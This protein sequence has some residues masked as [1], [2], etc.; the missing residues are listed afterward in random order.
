MNK[1]SIKTTALL[2][3]IP[4]LL[5]AM[6]IVSLLG[7]TTSRKTLLE[8]SNREM[9]YRLDGVINSIETSLSN[10]RKVV[11]TLAKSVESMKD[12]MT[13][14]DYGKVLTSFIGT[15]D[16]TF[17]GG[18]WFEPYAYDTAVQ[19]FSPYC[20]RENGQ[21][22]Y[23]DNYSLGDGVYYTEQ[24][25]YTGAMN[26][27]ESAVW[28]EP[29]YDDFAKISMVTSSAPFYDADGKL[30]GIA[31][32]DIDLTQLQTM[33]TSMDIRG[34]RAFLISS[35]GTYIADEDDGKLLAQN[36]TGEGTSLA[37]L[38]KQI[39]SQKNGTGSYQENGGNQLVWY[40]E[41]PESGW[42]AVISVSEQIL[43]QETTALARSLLIGCILFALL[44]S[45][46]MYNFIKRKIVLPLRVLADTTQQIA[47]GNLDVSLNSHADNE[48]GTVSRTLEKTVTQ[49]RNYTAYINEISDSLYSIAGGNLVFSLKYD[50]A[51][52][53]ARIKD[54]LNDISS[55]LSTAMA[56][57]HDSSL[58]VSKGSEQIAENG[59]LLASGTAEQSL[60]IETLAVTVDEINEAVHRN[61]TNANKANERVDYVDEEITKSSGKMN[62]MI[63]AM[64]KISEQSNQTSQIIKTIEEI[65]TQT[66]M[67][68]MNAAIEA[69]RAGEAGRGFAVV[70]DQVRELANKSA[71]AVK[72]TNALIE[73]TLKA[74]EQGVNIADDTASSLKHVVDGANEVA[75]LI[76]EISK[77]SNQQASTVTRIKQEI[78]QISSVVKNNSEIAEESAS[79]SEELSA[80]SQLLQELV[81]RF[82]F[83][84]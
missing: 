78:N 71:E 60:S 26:I 52:E 16:E 39:L 42:I 82:E 58:R 8:S 20:M 69:A 48:I 74:V 59:Q 15:N 37:A 51:G 29:Y 11:E 28:S 63:N 54:A 4:T 79:A 83:N 70:A 64:A 55:S 50:Y 17:G 1:K 75:G 19:Y 6:V 10:N 65:A 45:M 56:S 81:S 2:I 5:V 47:D 9:T 27:K 76:E 25:W 23:V 73:L 22:V 49:L 13:G 40:A 61:A 31:T 80:Q 34:G 68:S 7:Y 66:N 21:V 72:D 18:I 84:N 33:I 62:D 41:V 35:A 46:L 30:M 77:D 36:I 53:F 38:G 12:H 67:L 43:M 24:D 32:T 3:T 14:D 44:G 57:I